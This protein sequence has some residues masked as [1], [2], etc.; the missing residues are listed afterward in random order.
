MTLSF[1][2]LE[3]ENRIEEIAATHLKI[4]IILLFFTNLKKRKKE[5]EYRTRNEEQGFLK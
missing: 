4:R 1:V 2:R 5:E 3:L